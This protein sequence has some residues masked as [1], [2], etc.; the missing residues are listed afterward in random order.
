LD[1]HAR[2]ILRIFAL[3]KQPKFDGFLYVG[4]K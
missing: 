2:L 4:T 3:M 1:V